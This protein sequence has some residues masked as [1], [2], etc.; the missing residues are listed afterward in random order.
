MGG[1]TSNSCG[2]EVGPSSTDEME[3]IHAK[4]SEKGGMFS[5]STCEPG[6]FNS[7][8]H[9]SPTSKNPGKEVAIS[10]LTVNRPFGRHYCILSRFIVTV[11]SRKY[12]GPQHGI[13]G[14]SFVPASSHMGVIPYPVKVT[15]RTRDFYQ[16][17]LVKPCWG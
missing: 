17:L 1:L 14:F 8:Y 7:N 3:E 12:P 4:A 2:S 9:F 6:F 10:L 15:S 13:A 11:D 16:T 5:L